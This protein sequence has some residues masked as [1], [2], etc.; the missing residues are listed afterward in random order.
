MPVVKHNLFLFGEVFVVAKNILSVSLFICYT[1]MF[2][3]ILVFAFPTACTVSGAR[4][5]KVL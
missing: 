3:Y 1:K 2:F 5:V 4:R